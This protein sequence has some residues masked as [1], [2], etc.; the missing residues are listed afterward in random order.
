MSPTKKYDVTNEKYDATRKL[1]GGGTLDI[2][3]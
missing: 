3:I 1:W 2:Y